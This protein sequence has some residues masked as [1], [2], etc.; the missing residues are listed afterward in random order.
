MNLKLVNQLDRLADKMDA[1]SCLT[2]AGILGVY[3]NARLFIQVL[4][5]EL[6]VV[7]HDFTLWA[8]TQL[9]YVLKGLDRGLDRWTLL[10]SR[11]LA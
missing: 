2:S 3:C 11:A 7:W 5:N 9:L 1:S 10:I 6:M 4:E 8:A